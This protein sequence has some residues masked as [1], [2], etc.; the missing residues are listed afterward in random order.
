MLERSMGN[1]LL[2]LKLSKTEM[3]L[4]RRGGCY[5]LIML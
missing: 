2:F 1:V 4:Y 3:E 5:L